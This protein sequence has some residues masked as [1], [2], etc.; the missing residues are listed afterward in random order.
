MI[1]LCAIYRIALPGSGSDYAPFR[2]KLGV[3]I[4]DL[5]YT[6]DVSHTILFSQN[7]TIS[8]SVSK[9]ISSFY[10]R[11]SVSVVVV[12]EKLI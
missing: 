1:F 9:R 2:D 3:P 6:Y 7:I 8:L 12:I 5:W 10:D 4:I 11:C